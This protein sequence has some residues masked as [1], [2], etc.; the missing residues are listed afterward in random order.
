MHM[1]QAVPKLTF[2]ILQLIYEEARPPSTPPSRRYQ[3]EQMMGT[4]CQIWRRRWTER[5]QERGQRKTGRCRVVGNPGFPRS[6]SFRGRHDSSLYH[7]QKCFMASFQYKYITVGESQNSK[8]R[9]NDL[10]T[11]GITTNS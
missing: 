5:R 9:P 11:L 7:F 2:L 6:G 8:S 3:P 4:H 1:Y 10:Y